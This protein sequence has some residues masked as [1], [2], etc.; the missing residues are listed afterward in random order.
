MAQIKDLELI[1][2]G[3]AE[4][5]TQTHVCRCKGL[6]CLKAY[7]LDITSLIQCT[8]LNEFVKQAELS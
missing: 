8:L 6:Q 1:I 7:S 2:C 4:G 5:R 3:K